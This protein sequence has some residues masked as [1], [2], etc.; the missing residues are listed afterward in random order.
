MGGRGVSGDVQEAV[1]P[2][3][4]KLSNEAYAS[5]EDQLSKT[6]SGIELFLRIATTLLSILALCLMARDRQVVVETIGGITIKEYA[7]HTNVRAFVYYIYA[8][9]IAAIYCFGVA[10]ASVFN[11]TAAAGNLTYWV[12]F[13]LDQGITYILLA[14]AAAATEVGYIAEHGESQAMWSEVCSIFGHFCNVVAGST[15][16]T[17]V[18]LLA[19]A[20]L[21]VMSAHKLFRRYG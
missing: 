14:A 17:F 10:I 7:Q 1:D 6:R 2:N 19:L 20:T 9:G 18:A 12:L 4:E 21:S 11:L 5:R 8:N 13:L 15:A 3:G 16:V